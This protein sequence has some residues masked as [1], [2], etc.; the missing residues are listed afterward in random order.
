MEKLSFSGRLFL[1]CRPI[2]Q[3]T[4][5]STFCSKEEKLRVRIIAG[6]KKRI[7]LIV[8]PL[9]DCYAATSVMFS[10]TLRLEIILDIDSYMLSA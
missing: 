3:F 2:C 5:L 10:G 8:C 7:Q 1:S 9:I 6:G 4:M